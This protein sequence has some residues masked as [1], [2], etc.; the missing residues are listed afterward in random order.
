M[1]MAEANTYNISSQISQSTA[2]LSQTLTSQVPES[3]DTALQTYI[4]LNTTLQNLQNENQFL[5]TTL[6]KTGNYYLANNRETYYQ[7]QLIVH[8]NDW[9]KF[10]MFVYIVMLVFYVI[11]TMFFVPASFNIIWLVLFIAFPFCTTIVGE[12][13]F[14]GV[15][16]AITSPYANVAFNMTPQGNVLASEFIV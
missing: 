10:Y 5:Q 11:I 4:A 8:L 16:K 3:T 13:F 7:S 14:T 2:E 9:Y 6:Q 15:D 12:L 1:A